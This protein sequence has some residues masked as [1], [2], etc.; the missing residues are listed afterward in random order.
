MELHDALQSITS[1][2]DR[3]EA[4]YEEDIDRH[5]FLNLLAEVV[6]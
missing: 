3:D 5:T 1:R 6:K 2:G 4:I